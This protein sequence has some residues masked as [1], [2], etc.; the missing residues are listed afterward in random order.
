MVKRFIVAIDGP[1][2]AGK[3]SVSR[4]LADRLGA[5]FLDTG[6]LYRAAT[7]WVLRA[8]AAELEPDAIAALVGTAEV[9]LREGRVWLGGE[10]V[11]EAIRTPEV[12]SKIY[13]V[14]DNRSARQ[15]LSDIQRRIASQSRC[16][17]T[18]GRDQGTDVF[19]FADC[20]IFLTA[21]DE[22][23]ARRRHAQLTR[24]GYEISFEQI[25]MDQRQ[26][27]ERDRS[28]PVGALRIA[29]D[30]EVVYTDGLNEEEVIERLLDLVS[31]AMH[32][33][34]APATPASS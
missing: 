17:V 8:G 34:S 10:D 12:T 11:S 14:A 15:F 30:A 5:D 33:E 18:E 22:E 16:L 28:R 3:S 20:K 31:R 6:A 25:L 24:N 4:R 27:D 23:R 32:G 9:D 2:G 26:R 7:L 1:A 19:P 13:L 29:P 21:T